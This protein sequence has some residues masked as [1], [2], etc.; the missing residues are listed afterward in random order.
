MA[1]RTSGA[2]RGGSLPGD[3]LRAL[4]GR[5]VRGEVGLYP[6]RCVLRDPPSAPF[7][8]CCPGGRVSLLSVCP[9]LSLFCARRAPAK[10][11]RNTEISKNLKGTPLCAISKNLSGAP[12]R[13]NRCREM[14]R[15]RRVFCVV[16]GP[17]SGLTMC[18][19]HL[20][21]P[22]NPPPFLG[23]SAISQRLGFGIRLPRI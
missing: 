17:S 8:A 9:S 5:D 1:C 11:L 21:K 18:K 6:A 23:P 20:I 3:L 7:R 22:Y 14:P 15:G 13:A 19:T 10:M 2:M 4:V 16:L 12:L